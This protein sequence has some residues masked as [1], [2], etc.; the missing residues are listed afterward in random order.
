MKAKKH[1]VSPEVGETIDRWVPPLLDDRR[2]RFGFYPKRDG[3]VLMTI[4]QDLKTTDRADLVAAFNAFLD[5]IAETY[6]AGRG[7][8]ID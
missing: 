7:G 5:N 1:N 6:G 2:P 4:R 3:T 8:F